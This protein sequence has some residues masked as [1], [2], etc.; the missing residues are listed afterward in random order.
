MKKNLVILNDFL[1][2]I[3]P[4]CSMQ[5]PSA[6]AHDNEVSDSSQIGVATCKCEV[7]DESQKV[8]VKSK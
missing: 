8:M 1:P 7:N 2:T 5:S 3:E 4:S 6:H